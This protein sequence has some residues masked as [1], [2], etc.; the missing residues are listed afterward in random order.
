MRSALETS[1]DIVSV[2][3][4]FGTE[5]TTATAAGAGGLIRD[6]TCDRLC[7]RITPTTAIAAAMTIG[8][9]V[10]GVRRQ[11]PAQW[12]WHIRSRPAEA[13]NQI[14]TMITERMA[15]NVCRLKTISAAA[16]HM[17]S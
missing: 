3:A 5:R 2:V 10:S 9:M 17:Q 14:A 13:Q 15:I 16:K 7:R 1:E 12:Q 8:V 11:L 6:M 4:I